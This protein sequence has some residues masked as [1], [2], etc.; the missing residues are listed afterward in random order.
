MR[1]PILI[2]TVFILINLAVDT[3]IYIALK[4]RFKS[5]WPTRTRIPV[6]GPLRN[7]R[8]SNLPSAQGLLQRHVAG[9]NV[10]ALHLYRI[11]SAEISLYFN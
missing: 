3:Y 10:D 2:L 5:K 7:D 4:R 8:D 9:H 6:A 1:L 11:L